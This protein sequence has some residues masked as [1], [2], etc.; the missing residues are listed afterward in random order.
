MSEQVE[1]QHVPSIAVIAAWY[2]VQ[3][4]FVES[5]R[6]WKSLFHYSELVRPVAEGTLEICGSESV[7]V[8]VAGTH[9]GGC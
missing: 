4:I 8:T 6:K 9:P 5:A 3:W 1:Q 7:E 2:R